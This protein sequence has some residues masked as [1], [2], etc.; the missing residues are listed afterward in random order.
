MNL[1]YNY[2]QLIS[3]LAEFEKEIKDLKNKNNEMNAEILKKNKTIVILMER[4][5][6][7][8]NSPFLQN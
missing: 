8:P 1:K 4:F 6:V 3:Q 7:S 2:N 5:D